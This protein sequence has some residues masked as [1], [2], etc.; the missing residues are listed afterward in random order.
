MISQDDRSFTFLT[1]HKAGSAFAS[2]LLRSVFVDNGWKSYDFATEAFV[3][4]LSEYDAV[5]ENLH[6]FE[7]RHAFFG[8]LR[9][10]SVSLVPTLPKLIPIIHVR[11]PRDCLVSYYYS[12]CYSHVLPGPGPTR[13]HLLSLRKRYKALDVDD[14][15][16]EVL[17]NGDRSFHLLRAAA[18]TSSNAIVSRYEHMVA[19]IAGWLK[20]L[21]RQLPVTVADG[22][23]VH[24]KAENE[25][26]VAENVFNHKRQVTPGDF[27]R[28][29]RQSSQRKLT[30]F[31][32]D[33]LRY[34][35]Y[36]TEMTD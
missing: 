9:A 21:A 14:F 28:K 30:E 18:E 27:R 23:L 12:I 7:E 11:D 29:L 33:D 4:G 1:L 5:R 22:R 26:P 31:F 20:D 17:S 10:E 13:D 24:L 35:G 19:D 3:A 25:A 6:R 34:F 16:L 15:C 36:S 2:E 8:P 32:L